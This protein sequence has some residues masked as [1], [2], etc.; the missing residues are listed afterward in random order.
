MLAVKS[1]KV[2]GSKV[3]TVNDAAAAAVSGVVGEEP[4]TVAVAIFTTGPEAAK[5]FSLYFI[6]Q[7]GA[8]VVKF[9][10]KIL[11]PAV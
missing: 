6:V 8:P 4:A 3:F 10:V 2:I 11:L 7:V 5:T 1:I 9:V